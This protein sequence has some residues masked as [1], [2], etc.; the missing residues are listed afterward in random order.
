MSKELAQNQT[1]SR[2]Y[3]F[4]PAPSVKRSD[5]PTSRCLLPLTS[6]PH[7][8]DLQ[9]FWVYTTLYALNKYC[10][11]GIFI[12]G[13]CSV[14]PQLSSFHFKDISNTNVC[15]CTHTF[16]FQ[17]NLLLGSFHFSPK[18]TYN[19]ALAWNNIFHLF[20]EHMLLLYHYV[21]PGN[22][23]QVVWLSGKYLTLLGHIP[24]QFYTV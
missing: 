12:L 24:S 4:T 3:V 13:S 17:K 14:S 18:Q 19:F 9:L 11:P 15:T 6:F 23:S 2:T 8:P 22:W 20:S 21:S 10:R 1:H 16:S 7:F 5:W